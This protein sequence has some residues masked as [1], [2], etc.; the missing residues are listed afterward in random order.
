MKSV[1]VTLASLAVSV[2]AIA[3]APSAETARVTRALINNPGITSELKKNNSAN[4][5]DV[6]I[7]EV[8]PGIS[9]Y[10][11]VFVRQCECIP[12]TAKVSIFEDITP[13]FAD[14]AIKYS[15]SIEINSGN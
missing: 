9:Q 2:S 6:Q 5:V 8:K 3:G 12:S 11:L 13:T 4:L 10:N 14:G 7:T 1:L 15:T